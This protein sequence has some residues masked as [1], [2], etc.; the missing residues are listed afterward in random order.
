MKILKIFLLNTIGLA[1]VSMIQSLSLSYRLWDCLFQC[2]GMGE[3]AVHP[4]EQVFLAP[5]KV[6]HIHRN[7]RQLLEM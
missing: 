6:L 7:H 4:L 2:L 3:H 5:T 1:K